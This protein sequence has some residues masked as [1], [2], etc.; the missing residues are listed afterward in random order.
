MLVVKEF[1]IKFKRVISTLLLLIFIFAQVPIL[2]NAYMYEFS[3]KYI[4]TVEEASAEKFDCVLVLGAG[5]W[6]DGPSH[7]LEERLNR[8]VEVYNT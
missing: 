5:V 2:I 1:L 6:G 7:L 8:G 3:S 4:L